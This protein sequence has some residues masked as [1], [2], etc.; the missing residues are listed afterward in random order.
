MVYDN[1]DI[2]LLSIAFSYTGTNTCFPFHSLE[3]FEWINLGPQSVKK[4]LQLWNRI[5]FAVAFLTSLKLTNARYWVFG[6]WWLQLRSQFHD[7]VIKWKHFPCYWLFVRGI[8]RGKRPVTQ[9]F[10]VFFDLRLSK[11]SQGWW[12]GTPSRPVWRHCNWTIRLSGNVR[13]LPDQSETTNWCDSVECDQN[14]I[15]A[16]E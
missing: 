6:L 13:K 7:D 9:S 4:R 16:G 14:L 2:D 10:D 3:D 8:H 5:R 11:Q 1:V 12:F 15:M